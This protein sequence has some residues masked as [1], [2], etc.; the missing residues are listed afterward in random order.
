L[1]YLL[2][3]LDLIDLVEVEEVDDSDEPD[4]VSEEVD[5]LYVLSLASVAAELVSSS[6]AAGSAESGCGT[7]SEGLDTSEAVSDLDVP[8]LP[9]SPVLC[10]PTSV[11]I[12]VYGL[13]YLSLKLSPF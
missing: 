8:T 10:A 3:V 7:N 6:S 12:S 1:A 4:E 11:T 5:D 2:P 13:T 9:V